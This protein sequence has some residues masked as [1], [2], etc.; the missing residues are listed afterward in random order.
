MS[1]ISRSVDR[2]SDPQTPTTPLLQADSLPSASEHSSV[3]VLVADDDPV[4]IDSLTGLL[5]EWGY[6]PITVRNG[7]DA[8]NLLSANNGPSIAVL[9]WTLPDIYGT[10]ICRRLRAAQSLRY[11]YLILLT[12]RDESNDVVEGLRAGAD[13]YLRKPYDPLELRARLETGSRI[14]VQKA[15]RESEQRF[16]SAFEHAGVG[17]AL[18]DLSGRWLQ[19]NPALCDLLGYTSSEL[20]TTNAQA[21]TYPDDLPATVRALRQLGTGAFKIH[22]TEKRYLHKDG[23]AVWGLLTA[24]PVAKPNG[25]P[26]YFVTQVQDISKRKQAEDELRAAH[27]ESELFINSV[28]SILIG[29]DAAGQIRRWNLAAANAFALPASA[30]RGKSLKDCG[31]KW[32]SPNIGAEIDSWLRIEKGGIR[33]DLLFEKD[34]DQHFLGLSVNRVTFAKEK[35][36]GLLITGVDITERRRLEEQLKQAQKLEA[37]GQLAAGIAHEINTPTQY[38]GDN[39]T[40]VKQSWSAISDLARAAQRIDEESR[41]GSISPEASAKLHHCIEEADLDYLLDEMPKAIDQSLE[42][43]QRVAKIVRAMKEFSHPGSE[44]KTAFDINRAIE[45]TI[46]VARNEWKYVSEVETCLD[47]E[48][49]LVHC[50]AGEFNQVILNLLINAAHAIRQVV[51]DGSGGKGKIRVTTSKDRNGVEISI[52][53]TGCGIPQAI[54]SRIFEPF[55]TTK[56]VGQGTGQGLALAHT[57][58]VRRHGGRLWFESVEGKGS[59]FFIRL[60]ISPSAAGP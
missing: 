5:T 21:V 34:G 29:T 27:A 32:I 43:V 23:H 15:L 31:I 3:N 41:A 33:S 9:D 19:V 44:E 58:I 20:L 8:L 36:L 60:P 57:T 12:G 7:R 53:D 35:S 11:P 49:P 47:P 4:A 54:Q 40:F 50:H 52:H 46:T 56:P 14:V 18:V 48:L 22:Q 26:A 42:G 59:T 28:P 1:E 16:Q 10:E 17:M 13:D 37:I 6:T 51:G 30:V 55:F 25:E 2:H 24:S 38:V 45:T 39:T